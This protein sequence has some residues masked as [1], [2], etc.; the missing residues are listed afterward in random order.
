MAHNKRGQS[1]GLLRFEK[2]KDTFLPKLLADKIG[3]SKM[4]LDKEMRS[5]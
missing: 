1:F 5:A 4:K 2:L 3:L